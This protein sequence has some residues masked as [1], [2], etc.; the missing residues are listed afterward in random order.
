ME[1]LHRCH[2]TTRTLRHVLIPS[3]PL[4][5]NSRLVLAFTPLSPIQKSGVPNERLY[6]ALGMAILP[7]Q[8]KSND[9]ECDPDI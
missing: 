7:R 4:A 9:R 2:R 3:Y 1:A 6:Q 5:P 8:S